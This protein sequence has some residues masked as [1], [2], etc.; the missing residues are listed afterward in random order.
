MLYVTEASAWSPPASSY[1]HEAVCWPIPS[2]AKSPVTALSVAG[3]DELPSSAS[4]TSQV[5]SGTEPFAYEAPAVTPATVTV[6]AVFGGGET[7]TVNVAGARLNVAPVSLE[8]SLKLMVAEPW[9]TG[10][11]VSG[12]M[13]PQDPK[14]TELGLTVAT[15]VSLEATDTTR[16][17]LPVR[18]QPFLP[19]SFLG[20]TASCV[21][22][23]APPTVSGMTS[24]A[25]S[26][27]ASRSLEMSSAPATPTTEATAIAA[28]ASTPSP[29]CGRRVLPART[30]LR[31]PASIVLLLW[32]WRLHPTPDDPD[33]CQTLRGT[34]HFSASG[35]ELADEMPHRPDFRPARAW[36]RAAPAASA[37]VP[38]ARP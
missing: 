11:T 5:A 20:V 36:R 17:L 3:N 16:V 37:G 1:S 31:F 29:R 14:V 22:P 38:R 19:S 30:L 7:L 24:A 10:V 6:G 9:A 18:L 25:A 23:F 2:E 4:V 35:R 32:L 15:A 8:V 21:V 26:I 12:T 33:F 13:S 34:L 28:P 27:E